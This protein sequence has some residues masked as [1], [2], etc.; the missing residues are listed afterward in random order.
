MK[1]EEVIQE[2]KKEGWKSPDEI[3]QYIKDVLYYE[4]DIHNLCSACGG[5]GKRMYGSTSTW[6]GGIAGQAMTLGICDKCWGSGDADRPWLNL[7]IL[8]Q[9]MTKEQKEKYYQILQEKK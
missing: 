7:R 9:I 3:Q 5:R 2:L 8:E 6:R 1:R 4:Y